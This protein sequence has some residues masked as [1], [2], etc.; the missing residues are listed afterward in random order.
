MLSGISRTRLAAKGFPSTAGPRIGTELPCAYLAL[1]DIL[2]AVLL[3]LATA[4]QA[5][6]YGRVGAKKLEWSEEAA[7]TRLQV[8][9]G[10]QTAAMAAVGSVM[11]HLA[12]GT[13]PMSWGTLWVVCISFV[14]GAGLARG[15]ERLKQ[16]QDAPETPE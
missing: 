14:L 8:I 15:E 6:D 3:D 12:L 10:L 9:W 7:M 2:K 16:K 1:P 11:L 5:R 4:T 13:P